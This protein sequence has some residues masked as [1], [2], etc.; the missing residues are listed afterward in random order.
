MVDVRRG[1]V[2][3]RVSLKYRQVLCN[4]IL[5]RVFPAWLYFLPIAANSTLSGYLRQFS[6]LPSVEADICWVL[7]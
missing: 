5:R 4:L 3:P 6:T 7:V 1:S 2:L